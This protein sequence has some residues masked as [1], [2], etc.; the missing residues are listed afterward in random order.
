MTS[1]YEQ[2]ELLTALWKLGA[3]DDDKGDRLPTSHGILDRALEAFHGSL[4]DPLKSGLSFGLTSVGLRCFELPAILLAA[5]E[6]MLTTEPNPTYHS[7]I[8]TLDE[9]ASRQIVIAHGL[10]TD[11]AI[12]LGRSLHSQVERFRRSERGSEGQAAA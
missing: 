9:D 1:R 5:Q 11:E 2:A 8:V 10:T 12:S 4:P 6:A 7:A 3:A